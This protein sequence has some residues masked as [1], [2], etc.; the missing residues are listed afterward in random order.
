MRIIK[1]ILI[2][3]VL[4]LCASISLAGG[5]PAETPPVV[6]EGTEGE[7]I[8]KGF[9][10]LAIGDTKARR[11]VTN[12]SDLRALTDMKHGEEVCFLGRVLP[13][14]GGG[15]CA[16]YDECNT[17]PDD[18]GV[19]FE[20]TF[21]DGAWKRKITGD[22]NVGWYGTDGASIGD[23]LAFAAA[24]DHKMIR[25]SKADYMI[26]NSNKIFYNSEGSTGGIILYGEGHRG[27]TFT[28]SGNFTA[29]LSIGSSGVSLSVRDIGFIT[30]G[31]TTKAIDL[32][33]GSSQIE[34]DRCRFVGDN[35]SLIYS[36]AQLTVFSR[37]VFTAN[38]SAIGIT[39]DG[40][41]QNASI[42]NNR[43]GGTGTGVVVLNNFSVDD[44]PEGVR[45][46]N[47][48][49]QNT[50]NYNIEIFDSYATRVLDNLLE[51][52]TLGGVKIGADASRVT[53]S[54]NHIAHPSVNIGSLILIEEDAGNNHTITNNDIDRGRYG[55][56]IQASETEFINHV[57]I[58]NNTFTSIGTASL[59]LDSVRNCIVRGNRDNTVPSDGSFNT[60]GTNT[61]DKGS[62][63]IGGNN[64][65][66]ASPKKFE[67]EATYYW[68]ND[69][70]G[71][72]RFQIVKDSYDAVDVTMIDAVALNTNGG[73]VVIGGF[74]GGR[75]G[76]CIDVHKTGSTAYSAIIEHL[77]STGTEKIL[78]TSGTDL[79]LLFYGGTRLCF[80]GTYWREV[81]ARGGSAN[82]SG[83]HSFINAAEVLLPTASPKSSDICTQWEIKVDANFIYVC[84]ASGVWKRASLTGDY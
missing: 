50:G 21:M 69:L 67:K 35:S 20:P 29:M 24:N 42:D 38:S 11:L 3:L 51:Q 37:C 19:F 81:S 13:G 9:T 39:V 80:D 36:S 48:L 75:A 1:K 10:H 46:T 52:A 60:I 23:A 84:T 83:K 65:M 34:I 58:D 61:S 53:I 30:T 45:I 57:T 41:N 73:K 43:F 40:Y 56:E 12:Y 33:A 28:A 78:T 25:V 54:G 5:P 4:M 66:G 2:I 68:A 76:Q 22:V 7:K 27:T 62:Y 70:V 77:E 55:I 59:Y 74:E 6:P 47:N 79:E 26:T 17:K 15:G 44:D 14:D 18:G 49:F 71:R 16:V 32:E 8:R 72:S 64:W 31:T 82:Y 63:I